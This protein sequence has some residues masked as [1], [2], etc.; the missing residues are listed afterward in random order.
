MKSA[1]RG[2]SAPA[3]QDVPPIDQPESTEQPT[4]VPTETATD[5]PTET[6]TDTPTDIPTETATDVPTDIPTET[7]TDTPTETATDA[8][9]AEITETPTFEAT[10]LP[11]DEPTLTPTVVVTEQPTDALTLEPSPEVT[12]EVTEPAVEVTPE[13]TAE[14]EG[15]IVPLAVQASCS[16]ASVTI[17]PLNPYHV[18]FAA[19]GNNIASFAWTFPGVPAPT[20][21]GA[22]AQTAQV[23]YAAPGPYN[24]TLSCTTT[25]Q[26]GSVVL[27]PIQGTLTIVDPVVVSFGWTKTVNAS[28]PSVTINATSTSTGYNLAYQWF[29]ST[30]SDPTNLG[31]IIAGSQ[32]TSATYTYVFSTVNPPPVGGLVF[33]HLQATTNGGSGTSASTTSDPLSPIPVVL[34]PI[35]TFTVVPQIG[36]LIAGTMPVVVTSDSTAGGPVANYSWDFGDG[37]P[38]AVISG[39]GDP[40]NPTYSYTTQGT[41]TLTLTY[42]NANGSGSVSKQVIVAAPSDQVGAV[43]GGPTFQGVN[44]TTVACFT[45]DSTG[46]YV[47]SEWD[48]GDGSPILKSNDLEVCHTYAASATLYNVSL[49]VCSLD[50][51]LVPTDCVDVTSADSFSQDST[52]GELKLSPVALFTAPTTIVWGNLL[53]VTNTS[54]GE[55]TTYRWLID[56]VEYAAGNFNDGTWSLAGLTL[57]PGSYLIRLEIVGPGGTGFYEQI[58]T[59]TVRPLT[60]AITG[61]FNPLPDNTTASYAVNFN[62]S[63]NPPAWTG[64]PR[65]V[66]YA[67]TLSEGSTTLTTAIT[68]T[69]PINWTTYGA[70]TYTISLMATTSDGASCNVQQPITVEW[71]P[72]VC[73]I[74]PA[75]FADVY[76]DGVSHLFSAVVTAP[77]NTGLTYAWEL[78][79]T[80]VSSTSTYNWSY[81]G[82][83]V[84]PTPAQGNQPQNISYEVTATYPDG[85][86]ST[87]PCTVALSFNVKPWP[88]ASDICTAVKTA[89][90]GGAFT[91]GPNPWDG[92]PYTYTA[93]VPAN[94]LQGRAVTYTWT[95]LSPGIVVGASNLSTI[96]VRWPALP[97]LAYGTPQVAPNAVSVHVQVMDADGAINTDCNGVDFTH[98][99]SV[100]LLAPVCATPSGRATLLVNENFTYSVVLDNVYGRN[101]SSFIWT[102]DDVDDPGP[103]ETFDLSDP[104][105]VKTGNTSTSDSAT[106]TLNLA[107]T[108]Y[109]LP[110]RHYLLSYAIVFDANFTDNI[111]AGGCNSAS[112]KDITVRIDDQVFFCN[113]A[114]LSGPASPNSVGTYTY[115][116]DMDNHNNLSLNYHFTLTDSNTPPNTATLD[117]Q[118]TTDGV[119]SLPLNWTFLSQFGADLYNLS[120]TV[121]SVN[122]LGDPVFPTD[123]SC[124][125]DIDLTVGSINVN[126]THPGGG[127]AGAPANNYQVGQLICLTN[128]TTTMPPVPT[129][130]MNYNWT[131]AGSPDYQP[132]SPNLTLPHAAGDPLCFSYTT[133]ASYLASL[134]G[135]NETSTMTQTYSQTFR[136]CNAQSISVAPLVGAQYVGNHSFTATA[137]GDFLSGSSW[138][139]QWTF[140]QLVGTTW[141]PLSPEASHA[142]TVNR[143]F[144]TPARYRAVAAVTGCLG[145][146]SAQIDFEIL[147]LNSIGARFRANPSAGIAPLDVCFD[148][149]STSSPGPLTSWTWDF[150]DGSP[151]FITTDPAQSEPCHT[152][153]TPATRYR[154]ILT[155]D[156]GT[157][158]KT[159][160][161]IVRTY[162]LLETQVNFTW[163]DQGSGLMCFTPVVTP[164]VIVTGWDFGDS[165][166]PANPIIY[167][168][169]DITPGDGLGTI[170]H[171]YLVL[172]ET[173]TV[174]MH[175]NGPPPTNEPG[176]HANDVT[177]RPDSELGTPILAV[178]AVCGS[179]RVAVFTVTNTGGAADDAVTIRN[180]DS[181]VIYYRT[182][183]LGVGT[184]ASPTTQTF[185]IVNQSGTLTFELLNYGDEMTPSTV[186]TECN[187]PPE[188]EVTFQ[189]VG[190]L[191]VFTITNHRL[192]D[193]PMVS[194]QGYTITDPDGTV[195]IADSFQLNSPDTTQEEMLQIPLVGQNPYLNYTFTTAGPVVVV[196]APVTSNCS[197]PQ[198]DLSVEGSC[199]GA[200]TFTIT[201]NGGAMLLAQNYTIVDGSNLT[202]ASGTFQLDAGAFQ[203]ITL[204]QSPAPNDPYAPTGYTLSSDDFAGS[205]ELNQ[206]CFQ[207][208]LFAESVCAY[209][210]TFTIRNGGKSGDMLLD[211][212]YTIVDTATHNIIFAS[213]T[214]KLAS[215]DDSAPIPLTGLD[216][217]GSYTLLS[218]GF[219]GEIEFDATPCALPSFTAD[220]TC[221]YPVT[222][223]ITNDGQ[224]G[225]MLTDQTYT[226]IDSE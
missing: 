67:W 121:T 100:T 209:P 113:A 190:N 111:A 212:S 7:A 150:G 45:N 22:N 169:V 215:G 57:N 75:S 28:A 224:A 146:M 122:G 96:Q 87:I 72:I 34:P 151:L 29:L 112:P 98:T 37:L 110:G 206:N 105:V 185:S 181:G 126:Y 86:T 36:E 81:S 39:T 127:H 208:N 175:F 123:Y 38:G 184:P 40:G 142:A 2:V 33:I 17:D 42:S 178:N 204:P 115:T 148:D 95:I 143:N 205:I 223:T 198:P 71:A 138:S 194:A 171:T 15:G 4:D 129:T 18:T 166:D 82:G 176:E 132:P 131:V 84:A 14:D 152:Y 27:G 202:V 59:V 79:A 214:F 24:Y 68:P 167:P 183:T 35:V 103:V 70:G 119:V 125:A 155:V 147:A 5:A 114:V 211:Q 30:S 107:G 117:L 97:M 193:G 157:T 8:P 154:V 51:G 172:G 23:T 9:T 91:P 102:L 26:F 106:I 10:E 55:I 220:S 62:N 136:V 134:Q 120:V 66:T 41:F 219:A 104:R 12:L 52:N 109:S 85:S 16:V 192:G 88:L 200:F 170:C 203:T 43:I 162:S 78:N 53:N 137:L 99:V 94:L 25:A 130:D 77:G 164:G 160:S 189:C 158:T 56:G 3:R 141:T 118:L 163:D 144:T 153:V 31:A 145:T 108:T 195:I 226:V 182:L 69:F 21:T 187:Y 149:Q 140:Y 225:D 89:L 133:P 161:N 49:N 93:T 83:T 139:Y 168:P 135:T 216:P 197:A 73:D 124:D 128:T 19:A 11:T 54:T 20:V 101:I 218:S 50:S 217:Y 191:P 63:L 80:G 1:H 76:A 58:V 92:N 165:P 196:I 210:V 47:A 46:P 179:N 174:V 186:Q 199:V 180:L 60:C 222:F 13:S 6:A 65:T 201:N 213:G 159:A 64:T 44:G 221:A 207:P 61:I 32:Q 90:D 48:F 177:P 116:L 188:I 173:Y 74:S 156:N